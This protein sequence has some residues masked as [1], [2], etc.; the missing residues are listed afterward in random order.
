MQRLLPEKRPPDSSS[1]VVMA[2]KRMRFTPLPNS[3]DNEDNNNNATMMMQDD[4]KNNEQRRQQQ[5]CVANCFR[6]IQETYTN[7][8]QQLWFVNSVYRDQQRYPSSARFEISCDDV[9]AALGATNKLFL[10]GLEIVNFSIPF[11]LNNVSTST[12]KLML[13]E[14]G[15]AG[16]RAPTSWIVTVPAG[17]YNSD[18]L[19]VA[20]NEAFSTARPYQPSADSATPGT[21]ITTQPSQGGEP[22]DSAGLKNKYEAIFSPVDNRVVVRSTLYNVAWG[23]QCPAYRVDRKTENRLG[24]RGSVGTLSNVTVTV[25]STLGN[26]A[27]VL[28]LTFPS[29]YSHNFGPNYV[30]DMVISSSAGGT[31]NSRSQ[32]FL[33]CVQYSSTYHANNAI[34]VRTV[35]YTTR[36]ATPWN[37]DSDDLT[38]QAD[39]R[40]V[41]ESC[42]ALAAI[43][44]FFETTSSA[45]TSGRQYTRIPIIGIQNGHSTPVGQTTLSAHRFVCSLPTILYPSDEVYFDSLPTASNPLGPFELTDAPSLTQFLIAKTDLGSLNQSYLVPGE[46]HMYVPGMF[47]S[48]TVIDLRGPTV[49]YLDIDTNKDQLAQTV[50][51]TS[52]LNIGSTLTDRNDVAQTCVM[53][54]PVATETLTSISIADIARNF[55]PQIAFPTPQSIP[56]K[57]S[58][59]LTDERGMLLGIHKD[60]SIT[61]RPKYVIP[62]N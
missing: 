28:Q 39:I 8:L 54:I 3:N 50:R 40:G 30:F 59:S 5:L 48:D 14:D 60:W 21:T 32:T 13:W 17:T 51:F 19:L 36:A 6:S 52:N 46:S 47:V 23:I 45:A 20:L 35:V 2:M 10:S 11:A 15:V 49:I 44:G 33:S 1:G 41:S 57:L 25:L 53:A 31:R 61:L 26:G 34:G 24:Y 18:T 38:L 37:F 4:D 62:P 42:G 29:D 27:K 9:T 58:F 16:V 12:N 56:R 7:N 43:L 22:L 55:T